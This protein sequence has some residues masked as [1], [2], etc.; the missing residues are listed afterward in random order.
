MSGT[1]KI[2]ITAWASVLILAVA[3]PL[4]GQTAEP[5]PDEANA[6]CAAAKQYIEAVRRGDVEAMRRVWTPDGEYVDASGRVTKAQTML[7][8]IGDAP[9][10][11]IKSTD[12]TAPASSLR[13]VTPDVAI[14]DGTCDLG[15]S[16]GGV[17]QAGDSPSYG[18]SAMGTGCS[19]VCA[20][21]FR[22]AR[23]RATSCIRSS[24][25]L[26]SGSA[27]QAMQSFWSLRIGAKLA[28]TSC[29]ISSSCPKAT[30]C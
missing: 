29:E 13:F 30:R 2:I 5:A 7:Q 20:R 17:P 18:S 3:M 22:Q 27:N 26:A 21:Q 28:T 10:G 8:N 6:V 16:G 9:Q 25:C 11:N 4:R 19:T 24:G 23:H 15:A 14:E 12:A 1:T